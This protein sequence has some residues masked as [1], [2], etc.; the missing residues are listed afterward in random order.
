MIFSV[1]IPM[2]CTCR[3]CKKLHVTIR[4]TR[5]EWSICVKSMEDRINAATAAQAIEFALGMILKGK[6]SLEEIAEY[7]KLPLDEVKALAEKNRPV[8]T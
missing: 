1:T 5:K 3:L 4:Q 2:I 8:A 6:L 7:S